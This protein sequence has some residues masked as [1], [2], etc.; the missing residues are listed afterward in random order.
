MDSPTLQPASST[1]SRIQIHSSYTPRSSID[2]RGAIYKLSSNDSRRSI[3][4]SQ[5]ERL[6]HFATNSTN[7]ENCSTSATGI[8]WITPE[9]SPQLN[10]YPPVE[11]TIESFPQ[12]TVP[13]PPRSDSGLPNASIEESNAQA[14]NDFEQPVT[15]E[16]SSLG[17]LLPSTYGASPYDSDN[18]YDMDQPY[19]MPPMRVAQPPV[20]SATS[21]YTSTTSSEPSLYISKASDSAASRR[22]SELPTTTSSYEPSLR[23]ISSPYDSTTSSSYSMPPRDSI[24]S[25]SGL[26]HSPLPSPH[27][28]S[29]SSGHISPH[30]TTSTPR[31]VR[32]DHNLDQHQLTFDRSPNP[33]E[34]NPYGQTYGTSAAPTSQLYASSHSQYAPPPF[35]GSNASEP[36]AKRHSGEGSM[37]VLNQ[38]PK[39]QCWEHGCNGRQFSTFSNLLR[40]Q[41]EKSGSANKS[42]CPK[43]G[44]EF[45]RTTARNG[46][47]AH[48]KCTKQQRRSSDVSK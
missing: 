14:F 23:R 2:E 28:S 10:A 27:M 18:S 47:L 32:L 20:T 5:A 6:L 9:H 34:S 12:W 43:C 29:T 40:H 45:T 35:V 48:D 36:A 15:S 8:E 4:P 30:Y 46:H 31:F 41:R 1:T 24:L 16:M 21:A 42:Y 3:S 19:N 38:R 17:F 11:S 7:L 26:T 13:T 22:Q 39:P 33:Y 37:R 25:I 44:A